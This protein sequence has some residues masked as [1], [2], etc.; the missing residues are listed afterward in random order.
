MVF[1]GFSARCP[2]ALGAVRSPGT[3]GNA[4]AGAALQEIGA[5][6]D[7]PFWGCQLGRR[8]SYVREFARHTEGCVANRLHVKQ[9][10]CAAF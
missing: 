3:W 10:F 1:S 7:K 5:S 8:C 2:L 9:E 6:H 4:R